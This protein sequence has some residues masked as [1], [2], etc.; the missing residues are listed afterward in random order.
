MS[1]I[2]ETISEA[3]RIVRAQERL[4]SLLATLELQSTQMEGVLEQAPE[5]G[6]EMAEIFTRLSETC[7]HLRSA[8]NVLQ[9]KVELL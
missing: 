9:A 2:E 3:I 7:E 5:L 8:T 6:P 4:A 1:V